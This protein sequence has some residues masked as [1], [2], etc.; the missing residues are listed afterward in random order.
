MRYIRTCPQIDGV[1][2]VTFPSRDGYDLTLAML[3][4]ALRM[5]RTL[6]VFSIIG[7]GVVCG[8]VARADWKLIPLPELI[9]DP[10][11]GVTYGFLPV[12]LVPSESKEIRSII[13]PDLRYNGSTG[14]YPTLRFFDY[15]DPKQR[16]FLI[17]GAATLRGEYFEADYVGEDWFNG[18]MDIHP[19]ARRE[20]D[21][22][23]R[24]Y[25]YGNDTPQS[26]ETNY[27]STSN[28][29]TIATAVNLPAA[30]HATVQARFRQM[31]IGQ[32]G[33]T[34]LPQLVDLP[35][36]FTAINGVGGGT[37]VGTRFGVSYD[38]RDLTNI[39]TEGMLAD[40]GVEIVDSAL[41]SSWSFIKY[42]AEWK[43][44]VPLRRDRK[45]VVALHARLDYLQNGDSAPF[46]EKNTVGGVHSL[47]GWGSNRFTDNNRFFVQAE[48]RSN[49]YEREIFGVRAHLEVAPFLDAG[50]VFHSSRDFPA[51]DLHLVGGLGFRAVVVPQLVAYVDL[52]TSGSGL[53]AFTGIDYPF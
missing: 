38:T 22:F 17:A 37:I 14:A 29:V 3:R 48:F 49:V 40:C 36:A 44:F 32:G 20:D 15:P 30:L 8:T 1:Q 53:A 50:Q 26:H 35:F 45:L 46:F 51:G 16:Y 42:G 21:P 39:P 2:A 6:A 10:N 41:G 47:R 27:A 19:N 4:S 28:A 31:H 52:G 7:A 11:E 13:A 5:S 12:V 9:V 25:G 23:E 24:F 34:S 43:E 18:W 33:V